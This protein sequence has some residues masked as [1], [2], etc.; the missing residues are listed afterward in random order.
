[1]NCNTN[2]IEINKDKIIFKNP[3]NGNTIVSKISLPFPYY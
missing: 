3:S 2:S 1:M